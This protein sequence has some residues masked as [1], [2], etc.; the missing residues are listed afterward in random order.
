M[1]ENRYRPASPPRRYGDPR[2]STGMVFSTSFDGTNA[3]YAS[4]PRTAVDSFPVARHGS[5]YTTQPVRKT[6]LDDSHP[7]GSITRT[8]YTVRPRN[9]SNVSEQRRPISTYVPRP[10]NSPPRI[11]PT[12]VSTARDDSRP[13]V[14]PL[15]EERYLVPA[16]GQPR[17]HQRHASA[18]RADQDR[19][20]P[21]RIP[22]QPEYHRGGGYNSNPSYSSHSGPLKD[23]DFSYTTPKEQFLQESSRAPQ[24]RESYSRR[25]RPI[26]TIGI[27]PEYRI[28]QGRRDMGPPPSS[29]R[30]L[31]R[32]D[33]PDPYRSGGARGT[34]S[35]TDRERGNDLPVRRHSTRAPVLHQYRE[36]RNGGRSS[37][38]DDR[39]VRPAPRPRHDRYEDED[40]GAKPRHRDDRER[41]PISARDNDRPRDRDRERDRERDRDRDRDRE[42]EPD[43]ERERAR[44]LE[45]SGKFPE[46]RRKP[47]SRDPSP[48]HSGIRKGVA[49]AAG[50]A[51]AGGIASLASKASHNGREESDS[52]D[53]K[54]RKHRRRH[55]HRD[56]PE[57]EE[58]SGRVERD[59][60]I[61]GDRPPHD[62]RRGDP[63]SDELGENEERRERRKHHRKHRDKQGRGDESDTTEDSIERTSRHRVHERD[64]E[65]ELREP[66]RP[67]RDRE[68]SREDERA[69]P[70]PQQQ[71]TISPGE[72]EDSRPRR[73]Q[74]VEPVEK[75]EE[76]KPK[77]ILKKPRAVPF[78]EDPNPQREGVAPLKDAGKEGIPPNARWT[79]ISRALVNPEALEKSHERFEERDDYVIVLRVV[80]REEIMKFAE[81]TKEIRGICSSYPLNRTKL[82]M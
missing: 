5:I 54:E 60:T 63:K 61:N 50:L 79:K 81:K 71:R 36:D 43:R 10:S 53:R 77:G 16:S 48:E 57:T 69:P 35:D 31:E 21:V 74:L 72:D 23:E 15:R 17:H 68:A 1:S 76:F 32:I 58:L 62:H 39:D 22:R 33:R 9:N 47:R 28:P 38:K 14:I 30:I 13:H 37:P 27:V 40:R 66:A 24:R 55:N 25:E 75:K 29:A 52:D 8:E 4:Q 45:K 67:R 6:F 19:L 70:E 11:R 82:T 49:A 12:V 42:R 78:P 3:R 80:T 26:S 59:L 65:G 2:A 41:E 46:E 34:D 73:V 7:G 44:D 20:G 18:T 51:A 56:D 64:R